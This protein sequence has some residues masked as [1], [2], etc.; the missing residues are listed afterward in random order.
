MSKKTWILTAM[1][2]VCMCVSVSV[3]F[4]L[5]SQKKNWG[6]KMELFQEQQE[7]TKQLSAYRQQQEDISAKEAEVRKKLEAIEETLTVLR[8]KQKQ[9]S[10][11][12]NQDR[13][14]YELTPGKLGMNYDVEMFKEIQKAANQAGMV[15]KISLG[16]LFGNAMEASQQ[17]NMNRVYENRLGFYKE[18][19]Q[20]IEDSCQM[21]NTAKIAFDSNYG[22]WDYLANI[23]SD[24]ELLSNETILKHVEAQVD[25]NEEKQRLL[26]ALE[27]YNYDLGLFIMMYDMTLSSREVTYVQQLNE[28]KQTVEQILDSFGIDESAGYTQEEKDSRYLQLL[29]R[30]RATAD[31]MISMSTYDDGI[32]YL[33][34]RTAKNVSFLRAYGNKGDITYI[35]E[36]TSY[37]FALSSVEKRYYDRKGNPLYLSLNQGT[38]T[39]NDGRILEHTCINE[40]M[41]EKVIEEAKRI[42][43]EYPKDTFEENYQNY[44]IN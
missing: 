37:T 33:G 44:A 20:Y 1:L 39:L 9:L 26:Q 29:N 21:V 8:E 2:A 6:A 3:L 11:A 38:V 22:F 17:D 28:Q 41:A 15:G 19:Q 5:S 30:Y 7:L 16:G 23:Q 42:W 40:A 4:Y 10:V 12:L 34:D 32:L 43:E 27:K 13:A 18:L 24:E 31:F 14:L 36:S 25:W 35:Q